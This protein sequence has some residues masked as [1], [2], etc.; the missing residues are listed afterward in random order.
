MLA[1]SHPASL[2]NTIAFKPAYL[3]AKRL[4]DILVTLLLLPLLCVLMVLIALAICLDS[5]GP[6]FFRQTRI[7]QRGKA[8]TLLK[9]RSMTVDHDQTLHRAAA[10]QFIQGQQLNPGASNANLYKLATDQRITRVGRFIRK[11]SLDELPQFIHVLRGEMSLVGP[12]PPLAYEVELYSP[13]DHL[14][15]CGKPGLTGRWQVYG[16]SRV[17][18]D[19]MV[20]MDLAYLRE[21][22]LLRDIHL[23]LLTIPVILSGQGGA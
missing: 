16:R 14:R 6:I 22:S 15:L 8:F 18:F 5:P 20:Q 4:L 23:M 2:Q 9:F 1:Q 21:Q 12:R 3:R 19:T 7:G 17:P 10:R 11:T 13:D